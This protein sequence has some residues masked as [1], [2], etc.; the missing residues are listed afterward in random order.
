MIRTRTSTYIEGGPGH[1][2]GSSETVETHGQ[3]QTAEKKQHNEHRNVNI[4][5]TH[6]NRDFVGN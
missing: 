2:P 4:L 6:R 3:G 1:S 5:Q